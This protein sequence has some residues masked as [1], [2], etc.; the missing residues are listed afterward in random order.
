MLWN[1][2]TQTEQIF[3][4]LS[5]LHNSTLTFYAGYTSQLSRNLLLVMLYKMFL[6]RLAI[7]VQQQQYIPANRMRRTTAGWQ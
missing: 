4:T 7:F 2:N 5:I 1:T 6:L 3:T